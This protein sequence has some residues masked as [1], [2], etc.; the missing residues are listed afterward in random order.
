MPRLLL[1]VLALLTGLAAQARALESAPAISPRDTVSLVSD[2]DAVSPGTPFRIGLRF[3]LAP[4]W[5]T[6]WR[7]PGDAG[8]APEL[9]LTL[10]KGA[11]AGPIVWPMPQR[12]LEGP[13]MTYAY[14]GEVLLPLTVTLAASPQT[15]GVPPSAAQIP[16]ASASVAANFGHPTTTPTATPATAHSPAASLGPTVIAADARWLVCKDICVPEQAHFTLTVP[17]AGPRGRATPSAQAPLFAATD[18]R[19]PRPSPWP[20]HIAPD[21]TLWLR[22]AELNGAAVT[23]AWFIPATAGT[24]VDAAP[25]LLSYRSQRHDPVAQARPGIQADR[26]PRRRAGGARPQRP[27]DRR[28]GQRHA[29]RR[30]GGVRAAFRPGAGVRVPRRADPEPDALRVPGAGDEGARACRRAR[31]TGGCGRMRYPT[32]PACCWRSPRLVA[33]CWR[34]RA[35]G[36]ATG[37]GFQFASPVFVAAMAWLLF[38]VGLNLSGV[39]EIGSR[40][41]GAGQ[42]LAGARRA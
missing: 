17:A 37:W 11:V 24:I 35:A 19:L 8:V 13:V 12:V 41:A 26:E 25:Q 15:A 31:R 29:G 4:G 33:H 14:T 42:R 30:T 32:P 39:F 27:G 16:P 34:R 40:L 28:D 2:T 6:Y 1:I 21:G 10:P 18:R 5:H 38:G 9:D 7:N 20:A 3:R 23:D 22:G 36:S